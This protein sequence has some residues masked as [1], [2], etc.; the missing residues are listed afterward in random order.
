[1][2]NAM[3]IVLILCLP[4][5][6]LAQTAEFKV[7]LDTA[8]Q[9]I[10]IQDGKQRTP[11]DTAYVSQS[12]VSKSKD[13]AAIQTEIDLLERL[14]MLRRQL[15]IVSDER[16]TLENILKKARNAKAIDTPKAAPIKK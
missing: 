10:L 16:E 2:K 9:Y 7:E 1:M 12:L 11:F 3:H 4:L 6:S 5:F 13:K 14:V 15:A 8:G